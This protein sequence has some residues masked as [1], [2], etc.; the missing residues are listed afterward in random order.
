MITM[1]R[2]YKKDSEDSSVE[3]FVESGN[4][5]S[6]QKLAILDLRGN[7]GGQS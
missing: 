4:I 3:E 1:E 5:I 7:T 6:G 2:M